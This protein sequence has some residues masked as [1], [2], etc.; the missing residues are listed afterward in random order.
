MRTEKLLVCMLGYKAGLVQIVE[1]PLG[2]FGAFIVGSTAELV[3][4]NVEPVV[5]L[6]ML[7]EIVVTQFPGSL[8]LLKSPGLSSSTILVSTADIEGVIATAP[9]EPGKY[10]TGKHLDQVAQVRNIVYIRKCRC[11]QSSFHTGNTSF[12]RFILK[13]TKNKGYTSNYRTSP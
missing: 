7:F 13:Y 9:A 8:L 11:Y 4:V 6:S 12:N 3:K 5:D 1:K 10:I 2:Y